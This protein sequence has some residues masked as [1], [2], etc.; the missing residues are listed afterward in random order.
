MHTAA[1]C[2]RAGF[3]VLR[4]I[5]VRVT[6]PAQHRCLSLFLEF[7]AFSK[8]L[9]S[10]SFNRPAASEGKPAARKGKPRAISLTRESSGPALRHLSAPRGNDRRQSTSGRGG[11]PDGLPIGPTVYGSDQ[12]SDLVLRLSVSALLLGSFHIIIIIKF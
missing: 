8:A 10:P 11:K 7:I 3:G 12:R 6:V 5:A 2:V 4:Q 9:A 1:R